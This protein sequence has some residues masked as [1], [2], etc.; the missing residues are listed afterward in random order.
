MLTRFLVTSSW[1]CDAHCR[2]RVDL[3]ANAVAAALAEAASDGDVDQCEVDDGRLFQ[4]I[5]QYGTFVCCHMYLNSYSNE[6]NLMSH[7]DK[8]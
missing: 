8:R 4:A 6:L 1:R 2:G 5:A 3:H 7:Q